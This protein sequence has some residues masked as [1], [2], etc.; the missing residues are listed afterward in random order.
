MSDITSAIADYWDSTAADSEQEVIATRRS[1]PGATGRSRLA[2]AR[3][4]NRPAV[5]IMRWIRSAPS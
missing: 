3:P 4:T 1:A 2:A 5:M